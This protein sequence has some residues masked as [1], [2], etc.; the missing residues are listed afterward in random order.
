MWHHPTECITDL[1]FPTCFSA[2][3]SPILLYLLFS[4]HSVYSGEGH[5]INYT[6]ALFSRHFAVCSY[7][8]DTS[9][10][11]IFIVTDR[12]PFSRHLVIIIRATNNPLI[13]SCTCCLLHLLSCGEYPRSLESKKYVTVTDNL[14]RYLS[15]VCLHTPILHQSIRP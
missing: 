1:K 8:S 6:L 9:G 13:F 12:V 15:A 10:V 7:L 4:S 14:R 2:S 11:Y 5:N 3:F